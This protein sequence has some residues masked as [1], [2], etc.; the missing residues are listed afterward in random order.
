MVSEQEPGDPGEGAVVSHDAIN[1]KFR[2]GTW[3]LVR[4]DED[5]CDGDNEGREKPAA[6]DVAEPVVAQV[7]P[8]QPDET[9]HETTRR[10][11]QGSPRV[12]GSSHNEQRSSED[13]DDC[14][15]GRVIRG[16]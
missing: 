1:D 7:H 5:H 3:T 16:K 10:H 2:A 6:N 14:A 8:A 13:V 15:A 4:A 12:S 11:K 9:A